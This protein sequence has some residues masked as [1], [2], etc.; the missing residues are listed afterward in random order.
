MVEVPTELTGLDLKLA[1]Q[2][3]TTLLKQIDKKFLNTTTTTTPSGFDAII[4]IIVSD[5]R[6]AKI[7]EDIEKNIGISDEKRKKKKIDEKAIDIFTI[8]HRKKFLLLLDD[9]WEPVD[10]ANFGVPL[11]NR[12]NGSK[13]KNISSPIIAQPSSRKYD[14]KLKAAARD[15][16]KKKR[17]SALRILTRSSMRMSDKGEIIE[18]EVDKMS[19][20]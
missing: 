10:L 17:E 8:L 2:P 7:Q 13:E 5:T 15:S 18:D 4:F 6:L 14:V 11:P 16:F 12:E 9:I 3:K 19:R 20:I 1:K